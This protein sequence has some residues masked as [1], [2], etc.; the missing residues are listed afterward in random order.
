MNRDYYLVRS[1][2]E[3]EGIK[4]T[5]EELKRSILGVYLN[6][7]SKGYFSELF[8]KECPDG[9]TVGTAGLYPDIF[10]AQRLG[11]RNLYPLGRNMLDYSEV[12]LF[13]V[14]E[15]LFDH[16][17]KPMASNYHRWD[18]CGN[19]YGD[20][21]KI[22]GQEEFVNVVNLSLRIAEVPHQLS[23]DGEIL[24][25]LEEGVEELF[26]PHGYTDAPSEISSK[27]LSAIRKFRRYSA[28]GDEQREAVRNLADVLEFERERF[29]EEFTSQ[30]ERDLFNI[31]NNFSIRHHNRNQH[32]EYPDQPWLDWIFVTYLNAIHLLVEI[33]GTEQ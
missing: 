26:E 21:K 1:G 6:L 12:E 23:V 31:A 15:F 10:V 19:H 17:S 8:G 29:I 27:V 22:D 16:V 11:R 32:S 9:D 20:F 33:K 28:S 25:I 7:E 18:D 2:Q 13:G 24:R 14:I 30:D 4:L 5:T 3:S